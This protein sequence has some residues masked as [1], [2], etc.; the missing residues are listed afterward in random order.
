MQ[1]GLEHAGLGLVGTSQRQIIERPR[2]TALL[3]AA[4]SHLILLVAPAGYGKTTLAREWTGQGGRLGLWYRARG[5]A[6]DVAIVARSLSQ[7]LGPVSPTIE[8]SIREL[9]AT[10]RTPEDEPD[11]IAELMLEELDEWPED[12]WL[13]I[14]EYELV[15]ANPGP[16]RVVERLVSESSANVLI[17]GR[18][19]PSW[20]KPRDLLY[21]DAYEIREAALAMTLEEA[22]QVLAHARPA[23]AGLVALADGWPAVIGLAALLPGEVNPT[24]DAQSAL[25]DYV[26]QELFDQLEPA[27]QRHLV[28]LSVPATLTPALV[29]ALAGKDA[30]R[31]LRDS[32]RV[33]LMTAREPNEL[34]IHPLCRAFLEQKLS[35][36]GVTKE[37]MD[38]LALSLIDAGQWDDAFEAIETFGLDEHLPLLI[39]HALRPLLTEGRLAMIERWTTWGEQRKIASPELALA[40]AE[41]YFR[42]GAW[43]LSESLAVTC[44]QSVRSDDLRAQA[45][46]CAGAAAHLLDEVDRAWTH[47]GEAI[48]PDV[49]EDIRRRALWGR[50]ATSYWTKLP[51]YRRALTDLEQA[52]DAS[53]EHLLRL[54]QAG[55]VIAMRDGGLDE[56]LDAAVAFEPLLEHIEDPLVRCSFLNNLTY[57]LGVAARYSKADASAMRHIDDA[58]RFRLSFVLPTALVNQ[59]MAKVGLGAY[60]AAAALL[61]ESQHEDNTG[62]SFIILE[63]RIVRASIGLSRAMPGD[64]VEILEALDIE[65]ARSDVIGE[66]LA[67]RAFAEACC[68]YLEKAERSSEV[69]LRLV[70][71]IRGQVM[72][73]ATAAVLSLERHDTPALSTLDELAETIRQTGCYDTAICAMRASAGLLAASTQHSEMARVLVTATKRSDDPALAAAIG[74]RIERKPREAVLSNREREVLQLAAEGFHNDEIGRRLFISPKTVKTHLQNTYAK[75]DVK[76][77]TEAAMKAREAGLLR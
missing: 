52:I 6:S 61:D 49:P 76:S 68:G 24:S 71:D 25:F 3:D 13:V 7:A 26:A 43:T 73:S 45:H 55:L 2:L 5:R 75:L 31:V 60:T 4:D 39:E 12:A 38:T 70:S 27:V 67:T 64:A 72:L 77:R 21:G 19:R 54:R 63:R 74:R 29:Q 30:K 58:T 1:E 10:L 46:L 37:E 23:A 50:F 69:A 15:A 28:L 35:D 66:A 41:T 20:V 14:D 8:R 53:P 44:T 17:T 42:R 22:S 16:T 32:T 11:A 47:Y 62:D 18:E 57:A 9:L 65:D 34:D 40:H 59:A 36:I 48:A 56:A 33:G 51:H